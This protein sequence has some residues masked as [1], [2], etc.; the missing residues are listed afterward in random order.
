MSS[1]E[2]A[3]ALSL[4][5]VMDYNALTKCGQMRACA[6]PGQSCRLRQVLPGWKRIVNHVSPWWGMFPIDPRSTVRPAQGSPSRAA[7]GT[8]ARFSLG[9]AAPAENARMGGVSAA[10]PMD[11]LVALQANEDSTERKKRQVRRGH[12]LLDGLDRLKAAL[13]GGIVPA[14]QLADLKRQ[15]EQRR[16]NTDDPRLEDLLGHIEL[17]VAVEIAKLGR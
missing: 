16:E 14:S 12:D 6:A 1:E 9:S 11:A 15:L 3:N 17:R 7:S 13:L 8:G 2:H 4:N 10:M 5:S